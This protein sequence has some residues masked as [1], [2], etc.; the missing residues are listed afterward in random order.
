LGLP[1]LTPAVV[2]EQDRY[3]PEA[4]PTTVF[5]KGDDIY[6]SLE[7][8]GAAG[9]KYERFEQSVPGKAGNR[10]APQVRIMDGNGKEVASASMQY[11]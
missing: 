8:K 2:K 1:K 6:C 4:K 7:I 10:P 11:G 9:E 5:K 3:N